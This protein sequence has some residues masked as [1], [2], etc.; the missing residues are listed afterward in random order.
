MVAVASLGFARYAVDV[1]TREGV[2]GIT[3][4]PPM[5]SRRFVAT[6]VAG[7][8]WCVSFGVLTI[9]IVAAASVAGRR[10]LSG[11]YVALVSLGAI[12]G[13]LAFGA[14]A[15]QTQPARLL[16]AVLVVYAACLAPLAVA[17]RG[18]AAL[19]LL[20]APAGTTSAIVL[21]CLNLLV[22]ADVRPRREV[23]AY[24][25]LNPSPSGAWPSA[26]RSAARSSRGSGRVARS[27]RRR[28]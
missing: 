3:D 25:W 23:E 4:G 28:S 15:W 2:G 6:L 26:R 22:V 10:E 12:V 17:Y 14:R 27:R 11:V 19:V 18:T 9:A 8:L 5:W 7:A 16:V 21:A 24:G 1:P 20:L 13:G